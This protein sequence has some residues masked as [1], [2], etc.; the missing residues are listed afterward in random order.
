MHN[1]ARGRA[2]HVKARTQ[3][4]DC[5]ELNWSELRYAAL[6]YC[7]TCSQLE[8]EFSCVVRVAKTL[9]NTQNIKLL[10]TSDADA[11]GYHNCRRITGCAVAPALC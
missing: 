4:T 6:V 2:D 7:N 3:H 5:T 9:V 11:I 8:V 10:R 1:P